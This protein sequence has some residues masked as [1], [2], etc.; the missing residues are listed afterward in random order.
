[1]KPRRGHALSG[2]EGFEGVGMLETQ[3]RQ[4]PGDEQ[5]AAHDKGDL[6][7]DLETAAFGGLA[8]SQSNPPDVE[9]SWHP[10]AAK[11]DDDRK[12]PE[13]GRGRGPPRRTV[14]LGRESCI[15]E[16]AHGMEARLPERRA[17]PS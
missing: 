9:E 8:A 4:G 11:N 1:M 2:A 12:D 14:R 10:Q 3:K 7:L 16:R 13:H 15:A 5:G 6:A 17:G